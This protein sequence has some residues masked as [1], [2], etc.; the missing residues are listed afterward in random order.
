MIKL[1]C[2]EKFRASQEL[3][4]TGKKKISSIPQVFIVFHCIFIV[5]YII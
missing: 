2:F 1:H 5:Y 3:L 4:Y